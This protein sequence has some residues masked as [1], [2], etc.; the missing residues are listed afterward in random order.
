MQAQK[1]NAKG[2]ECNCDCDLVWWTVNVN[3]LV[4]VEYLL[5]SQAKDRQEVLGDRVGQVS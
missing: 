1:R 4:N 5:G 3:T 2:K